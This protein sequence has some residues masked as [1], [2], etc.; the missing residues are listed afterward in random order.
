[1]SRGLVLLRQQPRSL[2]GY[3]RVQI[4]DTWPA[5]RYAEDDSCNITAGVKKLFTPVCGVQT[6][7]ALV[8]ISPA[9]PTLTP[10]ATACVLYI[11]L[12][13]NVIDGVVPANAAEVVASSS[14]CL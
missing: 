4:A 7:L 9:A 1:M 14:L 3:R 12:I 10:P 6:M 13:W 2:I 5:L 11:T 8:R